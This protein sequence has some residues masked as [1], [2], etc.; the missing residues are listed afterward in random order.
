MHLSLASVPIAIPRFP[1]NAEGTVLLCDRST[2]LAT[3]W[4]VHQPFAG[5]ELL[6][7]R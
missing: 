1:R 5:V 7:A 2:A 3:L 6:L 4:L